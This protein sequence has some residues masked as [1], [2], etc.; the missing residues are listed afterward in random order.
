M[1]TPR[2]ASGN[3]FTNGSNRDQ[4]QGFVKAYVKIDVDWGLNEL[5]K[6]SMPPAARTVL[7]LIAHQFHPSPSSK[8]GLARRRF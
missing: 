2:R 1:Q 3:T 6:P 5:G 4:V 7:R 8:T